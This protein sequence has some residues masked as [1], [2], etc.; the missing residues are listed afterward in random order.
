MAR[1]YRENARWLAAGL[2]LTLC[3]SFGQTFFISLFAA[4]IK[5]A[6][7]LTDGGWGAVYTAATLI[8]AAFLIRTGGL[9]DTMPLGRLALIV[10]GLYAA[11]AAGMAVSTSWPVLVVLIAGLR[12]CGQGM[13]GHI[14]MTAMGRWFRA[15][16]GRAV[17]VA[18]LGY[19]LGEAVLPAVTV[20]LAAA[21][22]WRLAWSL[23]AVALVVLFAPLIRWLMNEGRQPRG[24]AE[25][26]LSAGLGGRHWGRRDVLLHW[27]FWALIP[28]LLA[29]G[30]IGTAAFFQ[31]VHVSAVKGWPLAAMALG[32]PVYAAVTVASS[33][34]CGWLVDRFGPVR[35]LP[36]YLLPMAAGI[37]LIGAGQGIGAWYAMMALMGLTQG[38]SG[39]LLGALWPGLYGTRHL[40]AVRALA[41][42]SM[43]FATALGPGITGLLID[44]G[45]A[46]PDQVAGFALWCVASSAL[47][48]WV[49][50]RLRREQV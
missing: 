49:A 7:G 20:V 44:R 8:S 42:S 13:M 17:A 39:T 48:G 10:L 41:T 28:G 24:S 45:I 35:L 31:Q 1:F 15:H 2:V 25:V 21:L 18:G 11:A 36:V 46:F 50:M 22:G 23:A 9:A 12:F 4:E 5:Q 6:H 26:D 27:L 33:L 3:S 14:G 19:S 40:G 38:G 37:T 29:P 30:F 34:A 43:V 16:R 32:Y 47:F